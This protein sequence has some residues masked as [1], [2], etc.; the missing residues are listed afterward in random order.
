MIVKELSFTPAPNS[1]SVGVTL[2]PI[3]SPCA[4]EIPTLMSDAGALGI[5]TLIGTEVS[6]NGTAYTNY[7]TETA[8]LLA[9]S[10]GISTRVFGGAL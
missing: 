7:A 4:T 9:V 3:L 5:D 6:P 8:Y 2:I 10:A 1:S